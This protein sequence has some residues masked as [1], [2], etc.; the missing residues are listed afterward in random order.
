MKKIIRSCAMLLLTAAT[1]IS[2]DQKVAEQSTEPI[3]GRHDIA[4]YFGT[5]QSS[6]TRT[7]G[8]GTTEAWEK[9]VN[10]ATAFAF[11]AYGVIRFRR[12]LS[13]A[14]IA[15]APKKPV[16]LIIP[17]VHE[18]EE[19]DFV[20]VANRTVPIDVLSMDRLLAELDEDAATYNGTFAD[21]TTKSVR[22]AGFAMS[23]RTR[24][25]IEH[26]T[27]DVAIELTRTVAKIEVRMSTTEAFR[28]KYGE[29]SIVID[30]IRL[31]RGTAKAY[32][33]DRPETDSADSE[34]D[35]ETVQESVE[36][37]NLFYI[38]GNAGGID[39]SRIL[40]TAEATYDFDGEA[41]TAEDRIPVIYEVELAGAGEG[42]ILRNGAYCVDASINGLTGSDIIVKI[43]VAD[44]ETLAT[45]RIDMGC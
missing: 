41:A 11:D 16:S 42:R 22:P 35:F 14:E 10:T 3:D 8:T 17:D 7:F 25:R 13:A 4:L 31:S 27:T 32:L 44:W 15:A 20:I 1:A 30:R 9:A 40:L 34:Q 2:C 39:G 21:V 19:Y 33:I 26:G 36:G 5:G 38:F 12:D 23:G 29:S 45:Q 6:G 18:D 43:D 24:C 28:N 37:R